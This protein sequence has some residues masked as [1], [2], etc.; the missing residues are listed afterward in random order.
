[1]YSI[2]VELILLLNVFTVG[3]RITS[4]ERLSR[5]V[6]KSRG[7][8]VMDQAR[9]FVAHQCLMLELPTTDVYKK[10]CSFDESQ[11]E[12]VQSWSISTKSIFESSQHDG[13]VDRVESNWNII[14]TRSVVRPWS[15]ASHMS[16][17]IFWSIVYF[18]WNP[19]MPTEVG[20]NV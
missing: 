8:I 13:V 19:D 17:T 5:R 2:S 10:K 12:W 15:T 18:E 11:F 1:M 6:K 20:C 4:F 16:L 3:Y 7:R 14:A 9:T